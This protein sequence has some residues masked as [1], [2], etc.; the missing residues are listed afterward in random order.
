MSPDYR[1]L[2]YSKSLRTVQN[3]EYAP[4]PEYFKEII[5]PLIEICDGDRS[6]KDFGN[7]LKGCLAFATSD[8][9]NA[10]NF[11][12]SILYGKYTSYLYM[13]FPTLYDAEENSLK[14]IVIV[15]RVSQDTPDLFYCEKLFPIEQS[16]EKF[17]LYVDI[18]FELSRFD[19]DH[20]MEVIDSQSCRDVMKIVADENFFPLRMNNTPEDYQNSFNDIF[21]NREYD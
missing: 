4:N 2:S 3:R 12:K 7:Y 20:V 16:D 11:L 8:N 6:Y 13:A 21:Q 10:G 9:P 15:K 1:E 17:N 14:M 5:T 18:E 19:E